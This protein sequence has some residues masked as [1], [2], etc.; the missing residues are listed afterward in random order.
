MLS[1]IYFIKPTFVIL[2]CVVFTCCSVLL[3]DKSFTPLLDMYE[4]YLIFVVKSKVSKLQKILRI[5]PCILSWLQK[6]CLS[7]SYQFLEIQVIFINKRTFTQQPDQ[8][9]IGKPAKLPNF[10]H[11]FFWRKKKKEQE[12]IKH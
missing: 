7:V 11:K 6:A 5:S 9:T 12:K 10:R 2:E 1:K 3:T 4:Y 8:A